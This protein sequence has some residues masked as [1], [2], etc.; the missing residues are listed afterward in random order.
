MTANASDGNAIAIGRNVT[1]A[2]GA[3][4]SIGYY[5]VLQVINPLA[6]ALRFLTLHKKLQLLV[7]KLR[8]VVRGYWYWLR[9][10]WR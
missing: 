4:T 2:G 3:G 10:G 6:S 8:R 1:S 7:I 9:Y 5:L